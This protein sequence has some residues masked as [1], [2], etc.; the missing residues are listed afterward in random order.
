MTRNCE[1]CGREDGH[2]IGCA[3]SGTARPR[4]DPLAEEAFLSETE[5]A[6]LATRCEHDGCMEPKK[7]WAG[8]GARPRYCATGH[9]KEK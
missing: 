3:S 1:T 6:E 4:H 2:W 5:E 7:A 9:K 8:R